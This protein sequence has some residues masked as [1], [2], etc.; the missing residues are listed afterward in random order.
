MQDMMSQALWRIHDERTLGMHI[1]CH[2]LHSVGEA[3]GIC[4]YGLASIP[5]KVCPSICNTTAV[6]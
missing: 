6:S 2:C 1:V 4:L 3:R 5:V